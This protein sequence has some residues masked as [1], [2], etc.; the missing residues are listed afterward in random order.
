MLKK[1]PFP[2]PNEKAIRVITNTDANNECDDQYAVAHVLITPKFDNKAIIA[3][4]YGNMRDQDSEQRSYNEILNV[5]KL[6]GLEGEVNVL[7]GTPTA[8]TDEKTAIESEGARY[9]IEEAMS[10]DPRPLFVCNLGAITNLASAYLIEPRIA[11]KI[12]AV[13][14]IGGSPYP[15]GGSEFNLINDINAANVIFKSNLQLWQV[16]S[17]VYATMRVSFFELIEKVYPYGDIGKYLVDNT[18]RFQGI[19]KEMINNMIVA[20]PGIG[21]YLKP[22]EYSS[23][24]E[25]FFFNEAWTLGDSPVVGLML[26]SALGEFTTRSAPFNINP[27]GSYDLSEPGSR[28]IRVYDSI[29]SKFILN[30][31]F[32][33]LKYYFG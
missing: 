6:M 7:H 29:D 12:T 30:D 20:N 2:F 24:A 21:E 23:F 27:D 9:I 15:D 25:S 31:L 33:K 19:F 17:N 22:H 14:W 3:E 1:L 10:D 28:D 18:M 16:P 5:V 4:Q 8:L 26:N 32:A 13:I 11:E